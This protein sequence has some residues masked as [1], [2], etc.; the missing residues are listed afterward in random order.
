MA[1]QFFVQEFRE[2]EPAFRRGEFG[3]LVFRKPKKLRG[4]VAGVPDAAG[5]RMR[6]GILQ[7]LGRAARIEQM[8]DRES[9][10]AVGSDAEKAVPESA[11]SDGGDLHSIGVHL[12][13]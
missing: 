11:A 13:M 12:A 1:E 3:R 10:P 4:P 2:R 9:R 6:V 8:K 5:S 7:D